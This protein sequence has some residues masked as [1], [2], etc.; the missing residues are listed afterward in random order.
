RAGSG[1]RLYA[2]PPASRR[3]GPGSRATPRGSART[4][5][6]SLRVA[7]AGV[8]HELRVLLLKGERDVADRA[9]AVLGDQ[10]VGLAGPLALLFRVVL[11]AV[12]EHH[13]VG[14]LLEVPGLAQ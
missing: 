14:V 11:L 1:A 6:R 2:R 8:V 13:E 3:A 7:L 10:Q 5:V 4:G 9:V 12:D